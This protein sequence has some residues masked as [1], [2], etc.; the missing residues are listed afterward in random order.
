MHDTRPKN[1]ESQIERVLKNSGILGET[2]RLIYSPF[3]IVCEGIDEVS[4][5]E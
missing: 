1:G 2:A 5:S 4:L 3:N